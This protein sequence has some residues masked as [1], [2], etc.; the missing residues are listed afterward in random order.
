MIKGTGLRENQ[1]K[2]QGSA[3]NFTGIAEPREVKS[4]NRFQMK[5]LDLFIH[6]RQGNRQ[7]W[8]CRSYLKRTGATKLNAAKKGRNVQKRGHPG[9]GTVNS[10]F[11]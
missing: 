5:A 2:P 10:G 1:G 9:A 11:R 6:L 8:K 4:S 3:F 7:Q